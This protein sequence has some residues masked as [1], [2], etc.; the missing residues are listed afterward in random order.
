[1]GLL[2]VE[3]NAIVSAA[4]R[5]HADR[6]IPLLIANPGEVPKRERATYSRTLLRRMRD[7]GFRGIV[8]HPMMHNLLIAHPTV[9]DLC[10]ACGRDGY[11]VVIHLLSQWVDETSSVPDLVRA[12]QRTNFI[13]PSV[14]WNAGGIGLLTPHSNVY[15]DLSKGYARITVQPLLAAVGSSDCCSRVSRRWF[16]EARSRETAP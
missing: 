9:I 16:A 14:Y 4:A 2:L 3:S 7:E 5:A 10:T 12:Y 15:F 13:V 11:P 1:M 8:L 6:L